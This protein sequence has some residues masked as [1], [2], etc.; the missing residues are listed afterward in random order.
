[1]S[2]GALVGGDEDPEDIVA[3]VV[4]DMGSA[5]IKAGFAGDDAPRAVFPALVGR[6]KHAGIMVGMDQK[7]A[8]VG[9]EAQAK[10]GVLTMKYPVEHEII[11]DFDT[12]EKVWHCIFHNELRVAPEECCV[13][14]ATAP[15]NPKQNMERMAQIMFENFNVRGIQAL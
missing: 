5:M 7:D 11:T 10:R 2:L 8:Y 4:M 13:L 6:C 3:P 12:V 14:L 9:D 1:M 15:L